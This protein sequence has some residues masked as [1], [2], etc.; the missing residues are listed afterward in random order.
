MQTDFYWIADM[1]RESRLRPYIMAFYFLGIAS[2]AVH[3]GIGVKYLLR[4]LGLNKIGIR[5][6][7]ADCPCRTYS[8]DRF[9]RGL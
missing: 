9:H 2:I 3:A 4:A 7:R 1:F 6:C 5:T 8:G